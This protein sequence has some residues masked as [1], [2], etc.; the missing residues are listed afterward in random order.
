MKRVIIGLA[1][2]SNI[3]YCEVGGP[4]TWSKVKA[5]FLAAELPEEGGAP[6]APAPAR[7]FEGVSMAIEVEEVVWIT[8][9]W[10]RTGMEVESWVVGGRIRSAAT[11]EQG[12]N[13][14][15]KRRLTNL[16]RGRR[17]RRRGRGGHGWTRNVEKYKGLTNDLYGKCR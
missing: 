14:T 9:R 16:D 6:G 7:A 17:C 13:E 10:K 8:E 5:C 11:G 1:V 2:D 12:V 3:S 15:E 4:R